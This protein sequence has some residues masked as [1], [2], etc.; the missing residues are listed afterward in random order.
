M[1]SVRQNQQGFSIIAALFIVVILAFMG[2]MLVTILGSSTSASV[3]EMQ[4]VRALYIAEGGLEYALQAGVFCNYNP[5][6]T[7]AL[8]S[9]NF[10]VTSQTSNATTNAALDG[11]TNPVNVPLNAAPP[12]FIIPGAVMIDSEYLFC[13]GIAGN[14]FTGCIRG[15][16]GTTPAAHFAGAAVTQCAVTSTGTV[17]TGFLTGNV[18]RTVQAT[19]GP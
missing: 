14:S 8:G 5:I 13:T 4:S 10:T 19:V 1:R 2:V 7:V 18:S 11:V 6:G 16:A 17:P 15:W 9:G 3:N 12:G